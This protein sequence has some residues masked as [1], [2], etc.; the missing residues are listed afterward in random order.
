MNIEIQS[1]VAI[2]LGIRTK[3]TIEKK[4]GTY[5]PFD[6]TAFDRDFASRFRGRKF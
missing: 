4:K 6:S 5:T 3:T 2:T 1:K